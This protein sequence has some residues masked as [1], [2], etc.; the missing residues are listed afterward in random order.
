MARAVILSMLK[1]EAAVGML[2]VALAANAE[3]GADAGWVTVST[4][5]IT[6]KTR[7]LAGS[8]VR[9]VLAEAEL[10]APAR[11]VQ[12]AVTNVDRFPSFM[13]YVKEARTV[14]KPSADGTRIV[15]TSLALPFIAGRDFVIADRM[16]RDLDAAGEGEFV[17]EWHVSD[18]LPSRAHLVRLKTNTGSWRVTS[19]G[20][21]SH[22]VYQFAVDPGG[23]IP[24]W[25]ADIG[26]RSGVPDV[27]HA[28]EKE[29]RRLQSERN[30]P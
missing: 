6:I 24:G 4:G 20:A 19:K 13:P 9:E 26:N 22:V 29:A 21:K 27:L 12:R 7:E 17:S 1:R 16:V 18:L 28:V 5:E 25:L 14:G 30:K 10:D 23:Q 2:V 11:D 8:G 15:Y 3:Q